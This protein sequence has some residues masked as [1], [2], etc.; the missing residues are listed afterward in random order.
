MPATHH[1]TDTDD[2]HAQ[3]EIL[4]MQ[5]ADL[6]RTI[7]SQQQELEVFRKQQETTCVPSTSPAGVHTGDSCQKQLYHAL[8]ESSHNLQMLFDTLQDFLFVID[9]QGYLLHHNPVVEK[10]LGYTTEELHRK[11]FIALFPH[12]QR[13]EAH[14]IIQA[15]VAGHATLCPIPIV[16]KNSQCIMVETRGARGRWNNQNVLFAVSRDITE[17]TYMEEA[18]LDSKVRYRVISEL[19]SD[20]AYAARVEPDTSFTLEWITDAFVRTTGFEPEDALHHVSWDPLIHPND[21]HILQTH[22]AHIVGS[23]LHRSAN[24]AAVACSQLAQ[25]AW[26]YVYC[27]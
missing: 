10:R 18:L 12:E 8:Q 14:V 24:V 17:H 15:M 6:E 5:V 20:F 22:R 13:K 7:A 2:L 19:S 23:I 21:I 4:R 16:T 11:H 26:A 9:M 25:K 3:M 1:A 27:Q